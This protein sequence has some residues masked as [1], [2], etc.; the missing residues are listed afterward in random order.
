[1]PKE[2]QNENILIDVYEEKN[3]FFPLA[4]GS[5]QDRE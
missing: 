3:G 1:L 4:G 5:R 2:S